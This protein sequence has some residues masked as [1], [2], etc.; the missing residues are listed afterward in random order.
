MWR[1]NI[2]N[3]FFSDQRFLALTAKIGSAQTAIGVMVQAW[4]LAQEFWIPNKHNVPTKRFK[5]IP[6]FREIIAVGFAYEDGD[7]VYICGANEHFEWWFK[8]RDAGKV[9]GNMR[10]LN[11]LKKISSKAK[12]TQPSYSYSYS[13]ERKEEYSSERSNEH[14]RTIVGFESF[15]EIFNERKIS[16]KLQE[17]WTQAFP[18]IP[19]IAQEINKALAWEAANPTRRKKNFGAFVTRWMTKGWDVRKTSRVSEISSLK[20]VERKNE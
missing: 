3:R 17:R 19:W 12:Q 9:G 2:E 8:R 7:F 6:H 1:I 20:K 4:V 13:K 5:L 14:F 16:L 18:D 11:S 15:L 10:H